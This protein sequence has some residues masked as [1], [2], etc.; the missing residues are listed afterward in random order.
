MFESDRQTR[1][2]VLS[3]NFFLIIPCPR[4]ET[5]VE[6]VARRG[7]PKRIRDEFRCRHDRPGNRRSRSRHFRNEREQRERDRC[8]ERRR[9]VLQRRR[10]RIARYRG[11]DH[12]LHLQGSRDAARRFRQAA[13]NAGERR[14]VLRHPAIDDVREGGARWYLPARRSQRYPRLGRS[15]EQAM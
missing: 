1:K 7:V 11:T 3:L 5:P 9:D 14:P 8:D 4:S 12:G 10:L 15:A 2:L 6:Q 13:K